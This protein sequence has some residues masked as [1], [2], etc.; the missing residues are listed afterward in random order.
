MA[1]QKNGDKP[2]AQQI[3][4]YRSACRRLNGQIINK[5]DVPC[6]THGARCVGSGNTAVWVCYAYNHKIKNLCQS[7]KEGW[8]P[9]SNHPRP[10]HHCDDPV[11]ITAQGAYWNSSD[12]ATYDPPSP[13]PISASELKK[14]YDTA[15]SL[16]TQRQR[17][18]SIGACSDQRPGEGPR[19]GPV[20]GVAFN[21]KREIVKLCASCMSTYWGSEGQCED[22]PVGWPW[23][24]YLEG[25]GESTI[26]EAPKPA[27]GFVYNEAA[28]RAKLTQL[29]M[30]P[31]SLIGSHCCG[32]DA[33]TT[34]IG[35]CGGAIKYLGVTA[36]T[37]IFKY[38]CEAHAQYWWTSG[39]PDKAP[40]PTKI[41][42]YDGTI[43]YFTGSGCPIKHAPWRADAEIVRPTEVDQKETAALDGIHLAYGGQ[44]MPSAELKMT[45]GD[46]KTY[47]ILNDSYKIRHDQP[48]ENDYFIQDSD[49]IGFVK[50]V[51][52]AT[53]TKESAMTTQLNVFRAVVTKRK[54]GK[55][56]KEFPPF[57]A[58]STEQAT[59]LVAAQLGADGIDVTKVNV[60]IRT[61]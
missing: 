46:G 25:V 16:R 3:E 36:S 53:T 5:I 26:K 28:Y 14:Y 61:Y 58:E 27:K 10:I 20:A 23:P 55:L 33:Y 32:D 31:G 45:L 38:L 29:S 19:H 54:N 9:D 21:S 49:Q 48:Y 15:A 57:N 34:R 7:C 18:P 37:G 6:D 50:F 13:Q 22:L 11:V 40:Y 1:E 41:K 24:R 44:K 52:G 4:D 8:V 30:N 2:T 35:T 39:K 12:E 17:G 51:A 47:S 42:G 60:I 43:H 56:V 59:L